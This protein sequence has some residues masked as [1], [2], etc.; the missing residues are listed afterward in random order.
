MK[1]NILNL[2]RGGVFS[3]AVVAAFAFTTPRGDAPAYGT[4]DNGATWVLVDELEIN[5]DYECV[6]GSQAC[7][8]SSQ[9]MSNPIGP[10]NKKFRLITP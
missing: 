3:L 1:L 6:P 7:T 5:E 9:S 8:Y 2:L 10:T 4:P